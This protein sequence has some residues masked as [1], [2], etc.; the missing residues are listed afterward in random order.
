MGSEKGNNNSSSTVGCV[1]ADVFYLSSLNMI[2]E[3]SDFCTW[4]DKFAVFQLVHIFRDTGT[5]TLAGEK[6]QMGG[7][8][9]EILLNEIHNILVGASFDA[10][11]C[12]VHDKDFFSPHQLLGHCEGSYRI[13]RHSP[14]SV[15]ENMAFTNTETQCIVWNKSGVNACQNECPAW[16]QQ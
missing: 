5:C 16:Y 11:L 10:A 9:S 8:F 6:I 12:V 3:T 1:S 14:P 2:Q 7:I 13:V 15:P 4:V